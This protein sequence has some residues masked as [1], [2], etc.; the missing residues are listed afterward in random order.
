MELIMSITTWLLAI[1]V[2]LIGGLLTVYVKNYRQMKAPFLAGQIIF[3]ALFLL[4]N[5]VS[6]YFFFTMMPYYVMEVQTHVFILTLLQTIAFGILS[7]QT[8]K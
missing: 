3:A 8:Y 1:N 2:L 4:H 7:V 6:F 5:L